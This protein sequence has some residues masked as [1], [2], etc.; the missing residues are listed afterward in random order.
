MLVCYS[1][2]LL[3][4]PRLAAPWLCLG[5]SLM[6]LPACHAQEL[7]VSPQFLDQY[8]IPYIKLLQ[9]PR[10]FVV[11]Y[12]GA[13]HA[14]FNQ[15][16]MMAYIAVQYLTRTSEDDSLIKLCCSS[17]VVANAKVGCRC[18]TCTLDNTGAAELDL[19]L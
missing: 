3:S 17:T 18:A 1:L 2:V 13:Y 12:P 4:L 9:Q 10:E 11:T 14:G 19:I 16:R 5:L 15:V 8:Q 6:L 7:L